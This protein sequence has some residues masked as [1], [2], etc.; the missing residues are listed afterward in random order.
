MFVFLIVLVVATT[1]MSRFIM[2]WFPNP[3]SAPDVSAD[4]SVDATQV[5]KTTIAVIQA[6]ID[7]HR[8]RK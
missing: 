8:G 7:L 1:L 2:Y 5:D 3:E 6:A 4:G